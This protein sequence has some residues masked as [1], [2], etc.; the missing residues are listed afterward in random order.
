MCQIQQRIGVPAELVKDYTVTLKKA[1]KE[2]RKIEVKD[3]HQRLNVLDF[4]PTECDTAE[5]HIKATN[6]ADVITVFEVRAY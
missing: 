6:G 1:G 5:I 3:N 2:V 4:E